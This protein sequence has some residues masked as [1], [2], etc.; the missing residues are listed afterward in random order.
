MAEISDAELARAKQR[1]DAER[2][3]RPIPSSV[4]FDEPSER[5][6]VDFTNGASFVFPARAVEGLETASVKDLADVTLL[7]ETGIHWEA[8][9]VDYT[10]SGL[11]SGIFGSKAFMDARRRGGQSRS[12]AK[13]AA[14]RANGAKG[15]RPRKSG[16]G[17]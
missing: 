7:G 4:R 1:W 12:E 6:V 17:V 5:I 10:I 9:D 8:L 3:E 2:A 14:S 11:M 13:I 16:S 15:G